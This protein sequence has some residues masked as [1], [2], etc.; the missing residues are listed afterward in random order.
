MTL[1][2]IPP[3]ACTLAAGEFK[4]RLVWIGALTRDALRRFERRDLVL[5]LYFAPEA[6]E[7]VR[8]LVRKEQ[9]CCSFLTFD[10]D[11]HSDEIRLIVTAP[12]AAREVADTLFGE[13][14]RAP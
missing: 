3:I 11:E 7:R 1:A 9:A 13:F 14:V 6:G 12:E 8:E 4:D 10:L 5:Q 2:Q